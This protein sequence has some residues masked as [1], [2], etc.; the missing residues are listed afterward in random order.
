MEIIKKITV[1]DVAG[2]PDIK[3]IVAFDT[4]NPGQVMPLATVIGVA[5]DY[6]PGLSD[7]GDYVSFKGSFKA[8]NLRTG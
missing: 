5:S 3:E 7:K 1:R 8:T 2:K 6:K 4:A